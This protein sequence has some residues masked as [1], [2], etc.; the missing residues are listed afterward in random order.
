[1]KNIR[2]YTSSKYKSD[3]YEEVEPNIYKTYDGNDNGN[4]CLS[5]TGITDDEI[6]KKLNSLDGWKINDDGFG[7]EFYVIFY[8][9][10]KYYR[11]IDDEQWIYINPN[12]N[13]QPTLSYVTSIVFEQEPEY[14][15]N[16]PSDAYISQYPLED[17][18]EKFNCE[19][20]DFYEKE[21]ASDSLNSYIE[22]SSSNV[23]DIRNL[24]SIVGKH[25]YNQEDGEYVKLI[26]ET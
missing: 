18:L 3:L 2:I 22:F 23:D 11:E 13:K 7:E 5:L 25:V 21:N 17:I 12:A 16:N 24:L 8:E 9:G 14:E 15:E 20:F 4:R 6:I 26:I 19:I 10:K 1:M